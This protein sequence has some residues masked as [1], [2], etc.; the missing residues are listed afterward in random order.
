MPKALLKLLVQDK[1]LNSGKV[2]KRRKTKPP[3]RETRGC[4][5]RETDW[6]RKTPRET[7]NYS[8]QGPTCTDAML[9]VE[10]RR[11]VTLQ[12]RSTNQREWLA[13][14]TPREN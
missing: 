3:R 14:E 1:P 2:R 8:R 4:S 13:V 9:A 12:Q 11:E 10:T 5:E 6:Q 7:G